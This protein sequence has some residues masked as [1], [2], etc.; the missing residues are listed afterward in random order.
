MLADNYHYML[1][2][3][4]EEGRFHLL[5][6]GSSKSLKS[7]IDPAFKQNFWAFTWFRNFML[8]RTNNSLIGS[9]LEKK[10]SILC[11]LDRASSS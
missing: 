9:R 3:I 2:N 1:R 5:R 6:C 4:P 8:S 7:I 10:V 11:L